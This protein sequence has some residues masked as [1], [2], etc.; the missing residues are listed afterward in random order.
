LKTVSKLKEF[1]ARV[2]RF[3]LVQLTKTEKIYQI[4]IKYTKCL[5]TTPNGGKIDQMAKT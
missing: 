2:A 1:V 5:Q 3:F 4:F